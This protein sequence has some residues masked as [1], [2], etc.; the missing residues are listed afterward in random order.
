METLNGHDW[1]R[2]LDEQNEMYTSIDNRYVA[3]DKINQ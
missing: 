3:E 1:K 2:T